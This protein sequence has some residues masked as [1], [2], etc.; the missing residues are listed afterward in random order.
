MFIEKTC[1]E[2]QMYL[3]SPTKD[4]KNIRIAIQEI[5][6]YQKEFYEQLHI[7]SRRNIINI[8]NDLQTIYSQLTTFHNDIVQYQLEREPLMFTKEIIGCITNIHDNPTYITDDILD[9]ECASFEYLVDFEYLLI[10]IVHK[11]LQINHLDVTNLKTTQDITMHKFHI[12]AIRFLHLLFV[13]MKLDKK[14]K[15]IITEFETN[16]RT[17]YSKIHDDLARYTFWKIT[18]RQLWTLLDH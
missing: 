1:R 15:E 18:A 5:H 4:N 17:E 6:Q 3:K 9:I 7:L 2:I 10:D 12:H 14:M 13:Y 8:S 16:I 11:L